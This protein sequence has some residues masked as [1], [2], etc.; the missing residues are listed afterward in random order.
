MLVVDTT[1]VAGLYLKNPNTTE[2]QALLVRD[3]HWFAPRLWRSEF[4]N[5]LI[6]YIRHGAIALVDAWDL[7]A[8]GERLVEAV[9]VET[10][11]ARVL[12]LAHA[13]GCSAYDCEYVALARDMGTALITYDSK[14]LAAFPTVA[15]TPTAFLTASG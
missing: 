6:Q 7:M 11:A 9:D 8:A 4:R 14:L 2:I 12:R 5:I 10:M 15:L 13:S 3:P 1:I